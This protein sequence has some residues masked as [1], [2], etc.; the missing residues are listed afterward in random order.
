LDTLTLEDGPIGYPESSEWN[1]HFML[2]KIPKREQVSKHIQ[3]QRIF[4]S[5]E[6]QM[7]KYT[8]VLWR[9]LTE[10]IV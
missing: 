9:N 8:C 4:P 7:V 2:C 6:R 5:G 1:Y 3:L 10:N